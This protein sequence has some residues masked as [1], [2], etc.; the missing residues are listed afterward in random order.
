MQLFCLQPRE[1]YWLLLPIAGDS[2]YSPARLNFHQRC[3]LSQGQGPQGLTVGRGS[4]RHSEDVM[5]EH[6]QM[7]DCCSP[8]TFRGSS[9][10]NTMGPSLP[11]MVAANLE[12]VGYS[13]L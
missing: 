8:Q 2:A 4:C 5:A 1:G 7:E 9:I 10:G 6:V 13:G 3:G 12:H 11:L